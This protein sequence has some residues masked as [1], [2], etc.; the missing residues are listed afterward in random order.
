MGI[1]D[2]Q[3]KYRPDNVLSNFGDYVRTQSGAEQLR[4]QNLAEEKRKQEEYNRLVEQGLVGI[5]QWSPF[6]GTSSKDP[7]AGYPIAPADFFP[8]TAAIKKTALTAAAVAPLVAGKFGPVK[9]LAKRVMGN[10][11]GKAASLQDITRRTK[12]YETVLDPLERKA[13]E[14]APSLYRRFLGDWYRMDKKPPP[15]TGF[16]LD[17]SMGGVTEALTYAKDFAKYSIPPKFRHAGIAM[18]G[19]VLKALAWMQVSPQRAYIWKT[20]GFGP[21]I[22]NQVRLLVDMVLKGAKGDLPYRHPITGVKIT[23]H[24]VNTAKNEL[25]S[26]IANP[27]AMFTKYLPNDPR[28]ARLAEGIERNIFLPQSRHLLI[29]EF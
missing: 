18:P 13:G 22:A 20:Y 6:F 25:R 17:K 29:Q 12:S 15:F 10:I 1:L 7:S 24:K 23:H 28:G 14:K 9:D 16:G 8:G 3:Y 21:S 4:Q 5:Q 26:Q 19:R 11:W 2:E 27:M